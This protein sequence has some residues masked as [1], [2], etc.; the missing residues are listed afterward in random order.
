MVEAVSVSEVLADELK[1]GVKEILVKVL[2]PLGGLVE[3]IGHLGE[4]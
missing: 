4:L 3:N 2:A 1:V